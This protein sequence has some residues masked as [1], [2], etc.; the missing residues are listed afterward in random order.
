MA[1]T[2]DE[3]RILKAAR[4]RQSVTDE[5]TPIKISADFSTKTLQA[6]KVSQEMF[7]VMKTKNM[8]PRFLYPARLSF[9]IEGQ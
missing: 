8:Q 2:Q 3:E 1:K 6:R 4:V 9:E 5:G 7:R